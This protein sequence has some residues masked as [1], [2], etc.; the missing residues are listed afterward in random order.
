MHGAL[1]G[2]TV[3][4]VHIGILGPLVVMADDRPADISRSR[5]RTFLIRLG[6][7]SCRLVTVDM[8]A[9]ALWP[10]DGPA[11]PVNAVQTLDLLDLPPD[12]VDALRFERLARAGRLPLRSDEHELIDSRA[13]WLPCGVDLSIRAACT[14]ADVPDRDRDEELFDRENADSGWLAL[15]RR[16]NP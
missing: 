16:P 12:A 7:D 11:D 8:L 13:R 4:R 2:G 14:A 10:E 6:L 3:V 1:F 9:S 5:L 15:P